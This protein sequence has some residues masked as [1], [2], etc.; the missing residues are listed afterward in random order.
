M[1]GHNDTKSLEI[2]SMS[3]QTMIQG[4]NP[5]VIQKV[6]KPSSSGN[7]KEE[8]TSISN[9]FLKR[10]NKLGLGD[11]PRMLNLITRYPDCGNRLISVFKT[12]KDLKIS[13]S[14]PLENIITQNISNIGGAVNLLSVM[15]E[16][17]IN[18]NS[19]PMELLFKAARSDSTV[20][21]SARTLHDARLLDKSS[22]NL[23]LAYPDESTNISQLLIEL[24]E[25]AYNPDSLIDKLRASLISTP[26]MNT[27]LSLLNLLLT[28][29][30]Y[31][32]GVVDILLR[33]ERFIDR[34][35][36]GAKKLSAVPELLNNYFDLLERNPENANIFAKNLLLLHSVSLISRC[37][38]KEDF[39]KVS[40]LGVGAFHFM[41]YLQQAGML[42]AENYQ[43]IYEHNRFLEREDVAPT[44]TGLPLMTQFTKE[45]L[46]KM[47]ALVSKPAISITQSDVG[48]FNDVLEE[49]QFHM[50]KQL[51]P[52][53]GTAR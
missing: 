10:L 47:L 50:S 13:L 43:K 6:V 25:H 40:Q 9:A 42:N 31:D 27:T 33:Q 53:Q 19:V 28:K 7:D 23:I 49:H 32:L 14:D 4:L 44:L 39:L 20:A 36:E 26:H 41:N 12:L 22:F 16:L 17:D 37:S 18:P 35:Y 8:K 34:I 45:E 15:N 5:G 48:R 52:R 1:A 24:Q 11:D 3:T 38:S 30:I 46:E 21:Q 51:G 29:D 2:P